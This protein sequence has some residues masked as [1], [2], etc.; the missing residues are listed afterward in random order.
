MN[1]YRRLHRWGALLVA[2]PFL[3]IIATGLLLQ[4]NAFN[5]S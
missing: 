2:F 1:L 5:R 4:L 3:V